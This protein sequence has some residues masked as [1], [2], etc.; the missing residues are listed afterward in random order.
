MEIAVLRIPP[1]V[2]VARRPICEADANLRARGE[3][4]IVANSS[5]FSDVYLVGAAGFEPTTCSTQN[6]RATRL[7]YTPSILGSDVDTRLSPGQQA[8][9]P[10][11]GPYRPL[12]SGW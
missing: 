5:I 6:C 2:A 7:R 9:P 10:P 3:L 12:N 1:R 8:V 4:S 11:D